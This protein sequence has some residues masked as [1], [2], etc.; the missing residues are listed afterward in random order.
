M[1]HEV[2]DAYNFFSEVY[3]TMRKHGRL[4]VVEPGGRVSEEDF[5]KTVSIA[6]KIGFKVI[7]NPQ[8][9]RNRAVLLEKE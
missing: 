1:V 7:D 6:K 5:E 4:L 2:S 8:I 9:K 3:Q